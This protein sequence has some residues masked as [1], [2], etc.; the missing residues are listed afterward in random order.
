MPTLTPAHH[1]TLNFYPALN[2]PTPSLTFKRTKRINGIISF[3]SSNYGSLPSKIT[4]QSFNS[5]DREKNN[6]K[7]MLWAKYPQVSW[8]DVFVAGKKLVILPVNIT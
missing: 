1:P 3:T 5:L 8:Q 2:R 7:R 4:I 6:Q